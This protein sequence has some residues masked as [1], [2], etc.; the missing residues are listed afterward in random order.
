MD[1]LYWGKFFVFVI[2]RLSAANLES[3]NGSSLHV[4]ASKQPTTFIN[5]SYRVC[6]EQV[7]YFVKATAV[8]TDPLKSISFKVTVVKISKYNTV[9]RL[10]RT[11]ASEASCN[12]LRCN[13][14]QDVVHSIASPNGSLYSV[15]CDMTTDGGGWTFV[16]SINENDINGKCTAGDR[17]SSERGNSAMH[18]NGD[19]NW[20]NNNTFGRVED[21]AKDDYKNK[22][23]YQ[24][25]AT[26]MMVW[27]VPNNTTISNYKSSAYIRFHTNSEF[28]AN[29]GGNLQELFKIYPL[30]NNVA[31]LHGPY[32]P[33][34]FDKGSVY[35]V[36]ES[37]TQTY[38][39]QVT[40]GFVQFRTINIEKAAFA[41]C[42]GVRISVNRVADVEH[43]CV[44]ST[45]YHVGH[46]Y[47]ED[48]CGDFSGIQYD[49][50]EFF[51]QPSEQ[52]MQTTFFIFYR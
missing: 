40:G 14:A 27:Y 43:F 20:E 18:P 36:T 26:D 29:E 12:D 25:N 42:P 19:G 2:A 45:S 24:L 44:G 6:L 37:F 41:F 5:L 46:D 8:S 49:K 15:Y 17:W 22:A 9:L 10:D 11:D 3:L 28:L 23:Y 30:K 4:R 38:P 13:G 32:A 51:D 52:L 47:V 31:G 34:V 48:Y 35:N 7:P 39:D 16:A 50:D 21:A 1:N 33:V